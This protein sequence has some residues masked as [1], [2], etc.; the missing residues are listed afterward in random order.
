MALYEKVV[1]GKHAE[2]VKC[3]ADSLAQQ[4][5]CFAAV[6]SRIARLGGSQEIGWAIWEFPGAYIEAELHSVWRPPSGDLLDVSRREA[7]FDQILFLSGPALRT[8]EESSITAG[9]RCLQTMT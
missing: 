1:P 9:C 7:N 3:E 2:R 4:N 6:A 8:T 5:E